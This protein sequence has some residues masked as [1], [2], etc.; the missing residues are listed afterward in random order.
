LQQRGVLALPA[1][2]VVFR[3]LPPMIWEQTQVDEFLNAMEE[4]LA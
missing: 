3:L 4:V 2:P 1:S